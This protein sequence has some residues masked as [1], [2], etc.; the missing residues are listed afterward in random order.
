M[1]KDECLRP[2]NPATPPLAHIRHC[3][4]PFT[5]SP[6]L[7]GAHLQTLGARLLRKPPPLELERIRLDTPDGD[8]LD[9]DLGPDPRPTAASGNPPIVLI[10]HG[11]EGS[12]RR[13]YVRATMGAVSDAGMRAVGMNFRSCSGVPNRLARFYHS[14]ET[15]D[16]T[17]VLKHLQEMFPGRGFGAVG[18]SLGGNVLLRYLGELGDSAP[19]PLA[20]AAA[21]SVPYD[22]AEG[23][24]MLEAGWMGRRYASYFLG[25][26]Q[27]K[28]RAKRH[29][30]APVVDLDRLLAA[31]TLR[32]FDDV[33]T[34]PLHGFRDAA[35]YYRQASSKPVLTSIR[36]PTH[37][38]HAM[39]DPF[40][41]ERAVPHQEVAEN[42]W[43]LAS[44]PARGGHVGFVERGSLRQPTFW[45]ESEAVRYLAE[46]L[47]APPPAY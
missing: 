18:F 45:A 19:C 15:G 41:P 32:E 23:S 40:L 4:R 22:L 36:V 17:L 25:S 16:L 47:R 28:A 7:P 3:S 21:I 12:T 10:L 1:N 27:G 26:L 38:L 20:A 8:F 2:T 29:L 11:L 42:P 39:D 6:W 30:L 33:A 9:L 44:F 24:G 13:A 37:L 5:A 34:A 35:E 14:G 31:R 46:I 43:L